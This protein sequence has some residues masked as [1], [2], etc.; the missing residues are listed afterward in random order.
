MRYIDIDGDASTFSS[1]SADLE[2]PN[3]N[4]YDI[5]YAALYWGAVEAG[6]APSN[7]VKFKGPIGGYND[8]TGT[9]I[10]DQPTTPVGQS[11]P[12][13]YYADVT[14]IV[15]GFTNS[16]GTYTVANVSSREGESATFNPYNGTGL[17]AGWSLFVV[18]EDPTLPGK[19][20]TSFN[21]FEVIRAVTGDVDVDVDGF[22]TIPT[23][24]VRANFAF[25]ALEGDSPIVGDRLR[26]NGTSLSTVDRPANNFFN[27]SVTQLNALPV[28]NRVPNSSNTLGFDTG[29]IA[30]PNPGNTVIN[31]GDTSAVV[32]LETSGDTYFQYF[33]AFAVEIIEPNVVL[34]KIVEDDLGND[35]GGETV[36]LGQSLNYV[37]GFQNTGNDDATNTIIRDVLPININFNYP[38]DLILPPGVSVVSYNPATREIILSIADYLV[39]QGDP[40]YEIRIET[41]VVQSCSLLSDACSNTINN[42]AFV[43]YQGTD[44][45]DFTISDDPSFSTNTGCLIIPQATN[46]LADLDDCVFTQNEIL[47]GASLDITAGSGY[48]SYSW[49]TSPSGT[50]VIGTTQTITVTSPGTYY[51]FNTA[52][53]PCQSIE[54]EF[55][56]SNFGNT[57]NNPVIPYADEVVTCPNDGKQ[58]PNIY[59]CGANDSTFIETGISDASSIMREQLDESSCTAVVNSDCANEDNTCVRN[60]VGTGADFPANTSGQFRLTLNYYGGCFNQFYFNVYQNLLAPAVTSTDIICTT[61]GSITVT[62][63]PNGYEYSLDGTTYQ[64][65]NVFSI[66]AAGTYTAYI[67]QT[68]VAT[69]PCIFTVPRYSN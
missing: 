21:G 43:T 16:L 50:P 11:F 32:T 36:G 18:Y 59:L 57:V 7:T 22:R 38:T 40:V 42:Q 46:F 55:I 29:I 10:Y 51:S 8:I 62:G 12:Y 39:E 27:S 64:S 25:A 63:V 1:S 3:P 30:V 45:P 65:S 4:C 37:I 23:G 24:P 5:V 48:D 58:L 17:S 6:S 31:N 54:Q 26:L 67:R 52:V 49:S 60:Q 56:V 13:A 2:V 15:A 69:N 9:V 34:T 19:S 44:N 28:N 14:G 33:F 68:G 41:E 47:C 66:T 20:I 53:A 61:P 35:V